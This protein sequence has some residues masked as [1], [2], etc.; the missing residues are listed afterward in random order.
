MTDILE[1]LDELGALYKKAFIPGIEHKTNWRIASHNAYP[2][3][4]AELRRLTAENARLS[5]E[6]GRLRK[7]MTEA[8]NVMKSGFAR[9]ILAH[10]LAGGEEAM[11]YSE[12][13]EGHPGHPC[14]YG[15]F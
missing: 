1:L 7:H 11:D 9:D 10:A 8:Y 13:T 3:L 14:E 5:T 12:E 2:R 15:D 4:A 6:N